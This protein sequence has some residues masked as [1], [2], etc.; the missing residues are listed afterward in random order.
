MLGDISQE[1]EGDGFHRLA[2]I[3]HLGELDGAH[4]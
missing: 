1:V 3:A 4:E 2:Q